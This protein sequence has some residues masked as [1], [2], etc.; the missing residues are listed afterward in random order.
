[1]ALTLAQ[2]AEFFRTVDVL[3]NL[4]R[5]DHQGEGIVGCDRC[6]HV[7]LLLVASCSTLFSMTQTVAAAGKL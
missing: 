3:A 4:G 1:V 5:V 7:L 2:F 6:R